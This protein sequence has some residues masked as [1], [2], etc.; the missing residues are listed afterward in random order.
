MNLMQMVFGATILAAVSVAAC[1][2]QHGAT[3]TASGDENGVPTGST[4]AGG[5]IVS[6]DGGSV[7]IDAAQPYPCPEIS[8]LS[9][10]SQ[11]IVFP[12]TASL[13]VQTVAPEGGSAGA[14]PIEW[15]TVG[16]TFVDT[17]SA[18]SRLAAPVF[19]CGAF[20]GRVVVTVTIGQTGSKAGLDA[21]DV[22]ANAP[23]QTSSGIL[24]CEP[25]SD[26]GCFGSAPNL[27][28]D[29]GYLDPSAFCTNFATDRNNCGACGNACASGDVCSGGTCE[30]PSPEP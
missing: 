15:S 22:C 14:A 16:G 29:A 9:I 21:G 10:S 23:D 20:T 8:S 17:N 27:C 6:N 28:G 18:T 7:A 4:D 12:Q 3:G 26:P 13:A 5:P 11:E 25:S 19:N 1:S 30:A 24:Y 2:S